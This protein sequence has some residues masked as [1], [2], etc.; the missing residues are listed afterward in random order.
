MYVVRNENGTLIVKGN[1]YD[2]VEAER[3]FYEEQTG[4]QTTLEVGALE[5]IPDSLHTPL[6][7][8]LLKK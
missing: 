8:Q 2:K 6:L 7:K 1:D 4:R 5:P 3:K